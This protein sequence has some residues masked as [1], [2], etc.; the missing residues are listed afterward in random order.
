M[1]KKDDDDDD[2][3]SNSKNKIFLKG[4]GVWN[5]LLRVG[6]QKFA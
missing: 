4:F 3:D 6:E 2:D 1:W 5:R